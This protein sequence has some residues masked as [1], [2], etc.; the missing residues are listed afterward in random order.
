[1]E[2]KR[3]EKSP[4]SSGT[5]CDEPAVLEESADFRPEFQQS[6]RADEIP[7]ANAVNSLSGPGDRLFGEKEACEG[8]GNFLRRIISAMPICTGTS[9]P[10]RRIPALSKSMA[11]KGVSATVIGISGG[12]RWFRQHC[13][14][15]PGLRFTFYGWNRLNNSSVIS[16]FMHASVIET[17]YL[18]VD[19]SLPSDCPPKWMLLSSMAPMISRRP[20]ARC[21]MMLSQT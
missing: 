17:P 4:L 2:G 21:A 13:R 14:S 12:K 6:R 16:Q 15:F 9:V 5:M 18:S 10:P 11:A 8:L 3:A 7:L 1:M 19:G 20:D